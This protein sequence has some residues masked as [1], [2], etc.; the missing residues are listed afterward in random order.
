MLFLDK[1][2]IDNKQIPIQKNELTFG[3][4]NIVV[5]DDKLL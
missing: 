4:L 1:N 5:Y 3:K 2:L